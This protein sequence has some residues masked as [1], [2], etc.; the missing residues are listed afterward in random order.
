[1]EDEDLVL[2][3]MAGSGR[4][5]CPYMQEP[6]WEIRDKTKEMNRMKQQNMPAKKRR[7]N[8]GSIIIEMT[9]LI[10]LFLGCIFFYIMYFLFLTQAARD[11]SDMAGCL[12]ASGDREEEYAAGEV[13]R[14]GNTEI[15]RV[16]RSGKWFEIQTELRKDGSDIIENIRRWQFASGGI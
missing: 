2:Q 12:Y 9:L 4:K 1:M 5:S 11:L 3:N 14:E 16:Q 13:H 8:R 7:E 15:I 6:I 10:P